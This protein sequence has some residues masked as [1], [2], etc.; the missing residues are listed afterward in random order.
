MLMVS[1]RAWLPFNHYSQTWRMALSVSTAQSCFD[2]SPASSLPP[3]TSNSKKPFSGI[4]T[5]KEENN[6]ATVIQQALFEA[7]P[8]YLVAAWFCL[9][10]SGLWQ[11]MT[12][13]TA[14]VVKHIF[15][16]V[17]LKNI[18]STFWHFVLKLN[19]TAKKCWK[20]KCHTKLYLEK[21]LK[22]TE[23]LIINHKL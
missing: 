18:Q 19:W 4:S 2:P 1:F 22:R 13:N 10:H 11:K 14:T 5:E 17:W 15:V 23:P 16:C 8:A 3:N 9:S 20:Y 12:L 7:L 6:C 21:R